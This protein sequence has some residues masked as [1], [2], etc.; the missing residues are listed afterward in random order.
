MNKCFL[1]I[2]LIAIISCKKETDV[3][4]NVDFDFEIIDNI[5]TVPARILLNNKTT[6]QAL[7]YK[8]T[9]TNANINGYDGKNP[10][11]IESTTPGS[12]LIKLE[13]WNDNE[14]KEKSIEIILDSL[15]I[16]K[17]SAVPRINN[18]SPVEFDFNFEGQG[19]TTYN[20][21]F[22][23]GIPATSTLKNPAAILFSLPGTHRVLLEVKNARGVKDTL[24]K[25]IIVRPSLIANF[26][27]I[28][29]FDDDDY[30]AP[31]IAKL[32]NQS[33]SA[34]NHNWVAA[35]G[36]LSSA[37]DSIPTVRFDNPGSYTVTYTAT[38]DK[39]TQIITKNIIVKPNTFLRKFQNIQLGINTAQ[40]SI[41]SFFSTKLRKVL[42]RDSVNNSNGNLI[43]ICYFGLSS[44]FNFNK[45]ISPDSVQFYT[46]SAIPNA[47]KT[48]LI[49]KQELCSCGN[50]LTNIDFDNIVNGNAFNSFSIIENIGGLSDFNNTPLPRVVLFQN[51]EG[52]KGAIKIKQFVINGND[53]YILCD[54]KNQKD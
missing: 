22:E 4:L 32:N 28:P 47:T 53:S 35:G 25:W 49:N 31:L 39:Q 52:K 5:Y 16:A 29:S 1:I 7:F 48:K 15:T 46:F 37:S 51:S 41:G 33:I 26:D 44:S 40:N 6:G 20:W 21:T 2:S 45:F 34:T 3:T 14:R 19:A 38:N 13:A 17:F 54:I 27:I 12:V 30:E 50:Q 36:I 24:S 42:I 11:Q 9:F 8:W 10:G 23:N 18:I 43:D